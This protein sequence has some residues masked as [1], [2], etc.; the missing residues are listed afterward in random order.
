MN[1]QYWEIIKSIPKVI[2]FQNSIPMQ[3]DFSK[4]GNLKKRYFFNYQGSLS[5]PPCSEAV[6]WVVYQEPIPISSYAVS[7]WFIDRKIIQF[8]DDDIIP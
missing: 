6:T 1:T 4:M 8:N 5:T 3:I 2:N 7:L